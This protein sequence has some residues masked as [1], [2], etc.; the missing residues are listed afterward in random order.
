M[1][2]ETA[3]ASPAPTRRRRLV[4]ILVAAVVVVAVAA[5]AVVWRIGYQREQA[6]L[7]AAAR[8]A[9]LVAG[10]QE[11]TAMTQ[12]DYRQPTAVL[13]RWLS[14]STGTL[15]SSLT[16]SGT[17]LIK[18]LQ[19]AHLV[20][21]GRIVTASVSALD[22]GAGTA[23]VTAAVDVSLSYVGAAPATKRDQ[24]EATLTDTGSGWKLT[25]MSGMPVV[26][27]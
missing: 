16:Q 25:S 21:S 27:R 13:N 23:S 4:V 12:V 2:S 5:G 8:T 7:D 1:T 24:I 9:A 11:I 6:R 19:Q 10:R 15:H 18:Q 3:M 20:T 26:G 17:A 22:R 14:V